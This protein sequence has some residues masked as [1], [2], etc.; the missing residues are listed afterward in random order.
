MS[1]SITEKIIEKAGLESAQQLETARQK[2]DDIRKNAIR[3][4]EEAVKKIFDETRNK[5]AEARRCDM[6]MARLEARKNTLS[7]RRTILE[8]AFQAAREEVSSFTGKRLEAFVSSTIESSGLSGTVRLRVPIEKTDDYKEL[9]CDQNEMDNGD[10]ILDRLSSILT[11][12]TGRK[13]HVLLESMPADCKDG[14]VIVS[15]HFDVDV[16]VDSIISQVWEQIEPQVASLLFQK[17][18]ESEA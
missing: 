8:E 5:A 4:S 7:A 1:K 18:K 10:L 2:A 3:E 17:E 15:D 13:F 16:S 12:R 9:F 11:I 14:F 6:L